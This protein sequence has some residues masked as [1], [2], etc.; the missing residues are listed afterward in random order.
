MGNSVLYTIGYQGH[1]PETFIEVLISHKIDCLID[2]RANAVSRKKGFSKSSLS[3]KLEESGIGYE[4]FSEA[5]ISSL[6]RR[7]IKTAEDIEQLLQNYRKRI[8]SNTNT[9]TKRTSNKIQ[10]TGSAVLMCFEAE[11][12]EC[13]RSV[14]SEIIA[15]RLNVDVCHI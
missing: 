4:H 10:E 6:E 11:S 3:E 1:T 8:T 14:L 9:D 5:G 13:H 2:V 12:S 15:N 7:N